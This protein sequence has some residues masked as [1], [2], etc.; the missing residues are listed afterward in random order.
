MLLNAVPLPFLAISHHPPPHYTLPPLTHPHRHSLSGRAASEES[1][2]LSPTSPETSGP[3]G[4]KSECVPRPAAGV[5]GHAVPLRKMGMRLYRGRLCWFRICRD[6]HQG[7]LQGAVGG[8][9]IGA[10]KRCS[11]ERSSYFPRV[12]PADVNT[13]EM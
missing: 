8:H 6:S 2:Q 3:C 13:S 7:Q 10:G 11:A 9:R 5:H 4:F 1:F 12:D